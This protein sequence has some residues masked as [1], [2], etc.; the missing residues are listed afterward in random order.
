M[1]SVQFILLIV[2]LW[3]ALVAVSALPMPQVDLSTGSH[4]GAHGTGMG[5][6]VGPAVAPI[7]PV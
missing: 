6:V 2:A 1:S 3:I 7:L 5:P 4:I